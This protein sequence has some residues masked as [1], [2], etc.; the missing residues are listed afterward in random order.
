MLINYNKRKNKYYT[1]LFDVYTQAE[2][3][4]GLNGDE[5]E[6]NVA[7]VNART[8]RKINAEYRHVDKVTDV[9]SFPNLSVEGDDKIICAC[10][11][12]ENFCTDVNLDTG[13]IM[14]GQIY[15]CLRKVKQQAKEYGHSLEREFSYLG[16]HGLL[17][18]LGYDHIEPSDKIKMRKTE[19]EI[20]GRIDI[21]W[22]SK[23]DL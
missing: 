17:H 22:V 1:M 7:M 20:L 9:L 2:Q 14:L 10:L 6:V 16:L 21:K 13:N 18:L 12:K 4:L 15:I 8:I 3:V 19:E 11:T 5:L 23:V